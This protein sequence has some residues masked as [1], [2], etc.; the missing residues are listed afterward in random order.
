MTASHR[1]ETTTLGDF[2][3]FFAQADVFEKEP[4][5]LPPPTRK[6]KV[7]SQPPEP[8]TAPPRDEIA[9]PVMQP[10]PRYEEGR[11]V[12]LDDN[13]E[14]LHVATALANLKA[15]LSQA[16]LLQKTNVKSSFLQVT[17]FVATRPKQREQEKSPLVA[18]KFRYQRQQVMAIAAQMQQADNTDD[19]F[20]L[21]IENVQEAVEADRVLIYRFDSE[22][23][24]QVVAETLQRG[25]TPTMGATIA[26]SCFGEDQTTSYLNNQV[27]AIDDTYKAGLTPYQQQLMDQFQVKSS[28]CIPICPAGQVWGLLVAHQCAKPRPWQEAEINLIYQL[29]LKLASNLERFEF[30]YKLKQQGELEKAVVKVIDKMRRTTDM[31]TIFKTTTQEVRQ[32]L[33]C[34]R[35]AVYRFDPNWSG[36][37][38]AESVASGWTKLVGTDIKTVWEDTHLQETQGGRYRRGESYAVSDIHKAGHFDCHLE[39]LEQFEVKA[40][41]IVPVFVGQTLWGLLGAYQNSGT[42]HWEETEVNFLSQIGSQFGSALQVAEFVRDAEIQA[43]RKKVISNTFDRIRQALDVPSILRSTTQE[44]R[45]LLKCDRVAVYR[46]YPDWSGEYVSEAVGTGWVPL[47]GTD[48]TVWEDTYLQETEGGRYRNNETFVVNDIY[49]TEHAQCHIEILEQFQVKAYMIA[50]VFTGDKLWGL[51]AAYQNSGARRWQQSEVDLLSEIGIQ[52]GLTVRQAELLREAQER[53]DRSRVLT[54]MIESVRKSLDV[55]SIFRTVTQEIR[56]QLRADRAA[57]YRFNPDWS[58]EFVAESVGTGWEPLVGNDIK[59]VW[60]DTHLQ[61]TQ[62]GRYRNG[63]TYVVDDIYKAG[64]FQCHVEILEQFQVQAYII[65]PIFAGDKLWGL[66]AAYQNSGARRWLPGEVS[67]LTEIG[68]QLG[69]SIQQAEVLNKAQVQADREKTVSRI[70]ENVRKSL[71]LRSI[72]RVATQEVRQLFKAD[73]VAVYRFNPDWSGEFV[74]ESVSTGWS[75]LVGADIKAVWADTHLQETQGGRYRNNE[76]FSVDDIYTSSDIYSSGLSTCH[77]E[78]LEQFQAK[79]YVIVPIFNGSK[80]WGLLGAYQ[81][82]GPRHWDENEISLLLQIGIQ[83]GVTLQQAELINE[84]Q[85]QAEREKTL[86]KVTNRIRQSLDLARQLLDINTIFNTTTQ[87]VRAMLKTDRVALYEFQPDWSGSFIAEAFG[88]GWSPLVGTE[89]GTNVE[90]TFLKETKGGR[91]ANGESLAV[92]D[93]YTEGH[94]PCHVRLLEKFQARAY[95][96]VP[97]FVDGKLWGI[98][99]AYENAQPRTWEEEEIGLLNQIA[100]QMGVALEQYHSL[101]QMRV[102]SEQLAA[103]A[104]KDK[105]ANEQLQLQVMQMLSAVRPVLSGDLTVRVPVSEDA[106]GT[107]ADAY[108]NTIQSLRKIVT[109]VQTVAVK[110]SETSSSSESAVSTL[111][112]EAQQQLH[113]VTQALERIQSMVNSTQAVAANAKQVESAVQQANQTVKA[114][115]TAMNKT[116]DG[117]M[118]I[119]ETVAETSK[120]IKRLSESSQKISKVVSLISNFTTQTQLLALNASIEATRAGEYGRG[121]SVVADEVRS[122]SRQSAEATREIE[123]LV[124]DIQA[125]TTEVTTAMDQGIQQVV[126]GT[127]L[128]NETRQQLNAIVEA[129]AQISQLVQGITQATQTQTQQSQLVTQ[130]MSDVAAIANKTSSD[131]SHIAASFQE[132]LTTAQQLQTSVGQ[133]KVN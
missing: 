120:K 129:T 7:K 62:G 82:L 3:D 93:I 128:V 53:A 26:A 37:F 8:P 9:A 61:D 14:F 68:P 87:E 75:P 24:G 113:Q 131:S 50:P 12:S 15:E 18:Q 104:A 41:V 80:L 102:Q 97:V 116:V 48:N 133:F 25:F 84:S 19:L 103:A 72:F 77:I 89:V 67:L 96:L 59:T 47:V 78:L 114:G 98:L 5:P 109:Q 101:K 51:I 71:E 29:S 64:H 65:A 100:L 17:E 34:D 108:N 11:T 20:N 10:E 105:A 111:S 13:R 69:L 127:S 35:V 22:R 44:V 74:S 52:L 88:Q 83:L 125:E 99:G 23:S 31:E 132:L 40:Y 126:G 119:R 1:S 107:I 117:I 27:V 123:K 106:I 94:D 70:I 4:E 110:V 92:E 57:I 66:L 115:D 38:I 130:A 85:R 60:A 122:L 45:Q 54:K 6:T 63:E 76:T 46:F 28:L 73:R 95:V 33:K 49:K 118:A 55:K 86:A 121:F 36:E 21:T 43:D 81:N 42:R 90:D 16:G 56:Q 2:A 30:S 124:Q 91:Y 112:Q 79:S 58:G 39:I 32:L